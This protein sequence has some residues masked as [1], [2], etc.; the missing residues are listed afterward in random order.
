[1]SL[2]QMM[3]A[4]GFVTVAQGDM[5]GRKRA[6][7]EILGVAIPLFCLLDVSQFADNGRRLQQNRGIEAR[8]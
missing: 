8:F 6:F 3:S 5:I 1:M 2:D 4:Q 7:I